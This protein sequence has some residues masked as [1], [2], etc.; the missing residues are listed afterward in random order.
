MALGPNYQGGSVVSL[1]EGYSNSRAL[2]L[3]GD[4]NVPA[5]NSDANGVTPENWLAAIFNEGTNQAEGVLTDIAEYDEPP[6]LFE[7]DAAGN[8]DTM[9]PGGAANASGL[10]RHDT[11]FVTNTTVGGTTHLKGGSFPCGLMQIDTGDLSGILQISLVPGSHRGYLA[12]SM[13]DM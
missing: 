11:A 9:Y 10:T 7:G 5:D 8:T 12:E 3:V 4:P 13:V 6:Y 1:V 2:P